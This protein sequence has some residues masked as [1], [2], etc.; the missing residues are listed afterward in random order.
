MLFRSITRSQKSHQSLEDGQVCDRWAPPKQSQR[1]RLEI[2]VDEVQG[3]DYD[4]QRTLHTQ[5]V[6]LLPIQLGAPLRTEKSKSRRR[7]REDCGS[8]ATA[9]ASELESAGQEKGK[10]CPG[11]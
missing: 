4:M 10:R 8:R 6:P 1:N 11:T 3:H 5:F 9:G 2:V 7:D